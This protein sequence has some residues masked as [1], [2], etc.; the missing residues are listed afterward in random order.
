MAKFKKGD[1]VIPAIDG[2]YQITYDK[3]MAPFDVAFFTTFYSGGGHYHYFYLLNN[4]ILASF[5]SA[6]EDFLISKKKFTKG[7][8]DA[9]LDADEGEKLFDSYEKWEKE[10]RDFWDDELEAGGN[11]KFDPADYLEYSG[12]TQVV[13]VP[14]KKVSEIRSLIKSSY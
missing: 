9:M 2:Y 1:I 5:H 8:I 10:N 7:F 12:P 13:A 4:G 6:T 14:A 11:I 3:I